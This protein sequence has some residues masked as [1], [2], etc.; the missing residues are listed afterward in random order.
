MK[1]GVHQTTLAASWQQ[2]DNI[3]L[4]EPDGM[5]W[6]L[7]E[8]AAASETPAVCYHQVED[9]VQQVKA[10]AQ[11]GD[12]VLVMSNGGFEGIHQR[13]LNALAE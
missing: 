2:A 13:L 12:H 3:L 10:I 6:S 9:I 4:F 5:K 11:P 8:V 7:A 1:M